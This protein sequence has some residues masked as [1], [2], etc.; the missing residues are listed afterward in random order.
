MS[1]FIL[2]LAY[3]RSEDLRRWY[4]TQECAL[5]KHRL[6]MLSDDERAQFMHENGLQYDSVGV[7]EKTVSPPSSLLL[8]CVLHLPHVLCVG[9]RCCYGI[10]SCQH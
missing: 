4:L 2:R 6:D 1:H 10:G 3:C 5:F 8:C 7:E 9:L